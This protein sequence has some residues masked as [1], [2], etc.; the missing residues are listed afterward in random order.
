MGP[1]GARPVS[2]GKQFYVPSAGAKIYSTKNGQLISS[3]TFDGDPA[4]EIRL[5]TDN[6]RLF[7]FHGKQLKD[8]DSSAAHVRIWD[9]ATAQEI[10]DLPISKESRCFW[11]RSQF[12]RELADRPDL[13]ECKW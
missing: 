11:S 2:Q 1:T 8:T 4:D 7:T 6:R 5:S 3:L 13:L 10:L 12:D 9:C